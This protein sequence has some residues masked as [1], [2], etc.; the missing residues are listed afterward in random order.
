M[1]MGSLGHTQYRWT[2]LI[3]ISDLA[4]AFAV[5]FVVMFVA[6]CVARM[7]PLRIPLAPR[8]VTLHAEQGR[9]EPL[10]EREGYVIWPLVPAAA[11]MAAVLAYGHF[12]TSGNS[13]VPGPRIALIQGC[14]DTQME[15]DPEFQREIFRHYFD[16]SR[17]ALE[18]FG[19]VDLIVWPETMFART[20][21]VTGE[22]GAVRPDEA[23]SDMS[24][25]EFERWLSANESASRG[26][27][28]DTARELGTPMILGVDREHF[29]PGGVRFYNSAAL[30]SAQ[31]DILGR[32]DKN[33][34]V[35]FGEYVPFAQYMPWLQRL[36]PLSVSAAAGDEPAAFMLGDVCLVPDVCYETVLSHVI[37]R[38][39]NV[40]RQQGHE[41]EILVNLTNDGWF[42]GSNELD[43]H[44]ACGVF[45][46]VECRR[47]LVIA[48]NTG[49]SGWI[50]A[51]GRVQARGPRRKAD[52]LLAEVRLDHRDSFYLRHG[53]W[54]AGLCLI[55]TGVFAV[56]GL[57]RR[58]FG[59]KNKRPAKVPRGVAAE[60]MRDR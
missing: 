1:T 42:W 34:L 32:Y 9:H 45:R 25:A 19:R 52:V 18:K 10:A 13:T 17:V 7:I 59:K 54:P 60:L 40:L 15:T 43:M 20:H 30:V 11:M 50:D 49:I 4:G 2:G 29:G 3:Q 28:G 36:T 24:Q 31:G 38:Q 53:D 27:M 55:A 33:H 47:P 41:P 12:R 35:M 26:V 39:I 22:P 8:E 37:R 51:D 58:R 5:S 57:W 56:G 14:V 48:A 16:L 21:W 46:A 44:F 23:P 6:A